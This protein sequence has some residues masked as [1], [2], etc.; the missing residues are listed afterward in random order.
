MFALVCAPGTAVCASVAA[1]VGDYEGRLIAAVEI[2]LEGTPPDQTAEAELLSLLRINVGTQYSAVRVRESLQSLFDSGLVASAR[3]EVREVSGGP[4]GAA[5]AGVGVRSS[6]PIRVRFIVRR[7]VRV[8]EVLFDIVIPPGAPLSEDELRARL[9]ML[10]PG[11]RVSEQA[12]RANADLIQ[13]YLRDRGFFRAEVDFSQQPDP[14]DPTGTRQTVTYRIVPGEQARVSTFNIRIEGFDDAKVRP[15]LKLQPNT[16]FTRAALGED[17]NRIRDAI[18]KLDHLAP[19]LED[20]KVDLDASGRTIAINLVGRIGPRIEV[21]VV[22]DDVSE[23]E[24]RQLLPVKREGIVDQSAIVEGERRL[25][26]KQQQDGYFFAEVEASCTVTPPAPGLE[27]NG[28]P[29]TCQTLNP[30]D[31]TGHTITI[32]YNVERGR[33]FKLTDIRLEGAEGLL[34]IGDIEDELRTRKANA[35][36]FIPLLGYGRGY[37]SRE[38]LEQDR[39]AIR[40][41]IRDLGYRRAEVPEIRQGVS[42]NGENLIITFVVNRGPLTRVDGIE[43]RGNKIYTD[44]RLRKEI[45]E[46]G[47]RRCAELREDENPS[48]CFRTIIGAPFSRPQARADGDAIIGLYARNGYIDAHLD[49]S[50]VELP[51]TT[52]PNGVRE[53]H[54]RLVYTIR[55]EGDK[56]FINQILVNGNV[57]TKKRAILEAI[58]L[59]PGDVLR[60]DKLTESERI[61]YAT[62]AFRMVVIRTQSAGTNASGFRKRDV[63][64]D[65]E[66]YRPRDLTYGGGYSTDN[67]P[68]GFINLRNINLFGDLRQGAARLRASRRQQLLRLEYFDPRFRQYGEQKFAPL[69]ISLQYLRDSTI[70][71][72]FRSTIDRGNFGIVQRLDEEG[73][74][75]DELG[76]RTGEPTINRL[77]FN[78]ETQRDFELELGPRGQQ[79]KRSTLFLRYSYE[80]VRL[81]NI[82]SLL[83]APLLRPDRAIRLSRLGAAFAR[84]TRDSQ[85]D[86]TRGQ[87]LALDYS[88]ALRQLG[89]NLSFS[90]FRADYRAYYRLERFRRTVLAGN[91]TL[92]L[93]SLFNPRD[94][95]DIPGISEADLRLPISERFFAGGST[96]LRGFGFEEAGPREVIAG[97][98]FRNNQGEPVA[99]NAF[100]VP[101]GGNALAVVNLEARTPLTKAFQVVPFYDGGNVFRRIGEI[102]GREEELQP[103]EDP[104]LRQNL[105]ARWTHTV[106]LGLRIKTPIGGALAVDYGFLLNPPEFIIPQGV[107]AM[108]NPFPPGIYRLKRGQL[109]FRFTQ[110]F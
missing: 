16:P 14:R 19:H 58:P 57:L 60:A 22:G 49:F 52:L 102:F 32:T 40:A 108:G 81:F 31:L 47:D 5:A 33:R 71:R 13:A 88:L 95:D 86:A 51:P 23:R 29:A 15:H 78:V 105:R 96:T 7:Q 61:L 99:L 65:V 46:A 42:I 4:S 6:A 103:G 64:I 26:N 80:D 8:G 50:I 12:L 83:I 69:A 25:R 34:S 74:P 20:P 55:N 72:F 97:G 35:L 62:E 84:D 63:I 70:T 98:L 27:S 30:E 1:D 85:F 54:V 73:K 3:V 106:G 28:T 79:L 82:S 37:T 90:K 87:F 93:A 17:I 11:A 91:I 107:D 92:G 36:G 41:R 94:R 76:N 38:L 9:N 109:H 56:V 45:E 44:A 21:K 18:I 101:I 10:E 39:R 2:E 77:T 104:A 48:A 43:I 53:E 68:L 67:G 110:T 59:R 24:A 89:G 75:I 66:E 100:T